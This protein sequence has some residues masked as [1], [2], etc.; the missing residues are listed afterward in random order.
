MRKTMIFI[1]ME[2][3]ILVMICSQCSKG[4][5]RTEEKIQEPKKEALADLQ[6][7]NLEI[8]IPMSDDTQTVQ[9]KIPATWIRNPLFGTVVFQPADYEDQFDPAS[10]EYQISCAGSC[11][12]NAIPGN[13]EN[14]IKGIKDTLLRPNINTGDPELDAI[15]ANVEIL[16]EEK[17]SDDGW[18]LAAAVTYPE[19]LS[20]S[21]YIPKVVISS[22]RHHPEDKFFVQTS[23]RVNLKQKDELLTVLMKACKSTD[24]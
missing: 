19:H 12:P 20:S 10:I 9:A 7:K 8:Q 4:N 21:L 2:C 17:F 5:D 14:K 1:L 13:I 23:A 16:L 15:R 24:Y 11:D 22:F 6:E 18:I 3:L